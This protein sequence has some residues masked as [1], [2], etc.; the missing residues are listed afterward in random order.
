MAN[1]FE[2]VTP[3]GLAMILSEDLTGKSGRILDVARQ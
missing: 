3:Q 1:I 2:I